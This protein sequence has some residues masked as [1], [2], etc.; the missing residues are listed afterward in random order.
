MPGL[1]NVGRTA[2]YF[3][4]GRYATLEQVIDFYDRGGGLGLGLDV[5]N[6]DPEVRPLH[7]SP[8]EKRVLLLFL[9]Q[10]LDDAR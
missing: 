4:N 2:P 10:A 8:A 3:H 9:R 1:R 7:L 5:P 6:Q